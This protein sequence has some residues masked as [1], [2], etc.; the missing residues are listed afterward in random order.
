MTLALGTGMAAA[1]NPC[2]VGL[3]PSYVGFLLGSEAPRSWP[4]AVPQGL[5]IG[6][7]M[8]AG[9]L[10]VFGTVAATFSLVAPWLGP[11]LHVVGILIGALLA[12]WGTFMLV[13]P[14]GFT[15]SPRIPYPAGN[16]R[17]GVFGAYLYGVVFALAS[18][19]CTFPLFL[20]L[21][22][23]APSAGSGPGAVRVVLAYGV[24]MGLVVTT[25]AVLAR[26]ARATA[27]RIVRRAGPLLARSMGAFVLASGLLVLGYWLSAL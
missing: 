2:G 21:L 13:W 10:T 5:R 22:L 19:G 7:A 20:S 12:L 1:F 24:G 3:L 26:L 9:L 15:L 25:L 17:R 11:H 18:L 8:T 27:Q 16:S 14:D 4:E 6:G 23:Q